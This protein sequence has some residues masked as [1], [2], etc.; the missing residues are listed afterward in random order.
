MKKLIAFLLAATMSFGAMTTMAFA[1]TTP[2][3]EAQTGTQEVDGEGTKVNFP[4]ATPTVG[5]ASTNFYVDVTLSSTDGSGDASN[6]NVTVPLFVK[7]VAP[8]AGGNIV[9]PDSTAYK[10]TNNCMFELEVTK[11]KVE[12]LDS[13][14]AEKNRVTLV[15]LESN[16]TYDDYNFTNSDVNEMMIALNDDVITVSDNVTLTNTEWKISPATVNEGA[17]TAVDTGIEIKGKSSQLQF[18]AEKQPAFSVTYTIEPVKS[19]QP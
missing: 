5:S 1:T 11:M 9:A 14:L 2:S 13:S 3:F 4:E 16:T 12:A 7:F 18:F 6:I 8:A 17:F 15:A 19:T 10:F